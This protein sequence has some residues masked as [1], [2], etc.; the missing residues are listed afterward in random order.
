M[1]ESFERRADNENNAH[2]TVCQQFA[3]TAQKN[4]NPNFDSQQCYSDC[5]KFPSQMIYYPPTNPSSSSLTGW[6]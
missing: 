2:G 4:K 5:H 3:V 1:N 6:W